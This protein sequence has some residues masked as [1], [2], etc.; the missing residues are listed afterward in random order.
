MLHLLNLFLILLSAITNA[1]AAES[2]SCKFA[3]GSNF[4][5]DIPQMSVPADLPDGTLLYKSPVT[6]LKL[7]CTYTPDTGIYTSGTGV[8][9]TT[10]SDFN[11]LQ[12][13]KKGIK[14]TIYLNDIPI[15][16]TVAPKQL[17]T[18]STGTSTNPS[19]FSTDVNVYF[20]IVVDRSRGPLPESGD[21]LVGS[22]ESIYFYIKRLYWPRA[23]IGFRT[24]KITAIPCSM[25]MTISPNTLDWG[26][27]QAAKLESG[28][29]F[30]ETF[31][32]LFNK[33]STCTLSG[34]GLFGINVWFDRMGGI[35]NADGSLDLNNGTGL[36]IRDSDGVVVP[37]DTYYSIPDVRVDS[38]IRKNFTAVVQKTS[39][40]DIKTGMFNTVLIVRMNYY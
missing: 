33:K 30:P 22:F 1:Y 4:I 39:G 29:E 12:N 2:G 28:S 9:Y 32:I 26:T 23:V 3:T 31:S 21:Q 37:F 25:D 7:N 6:Q 11:D 20:T 10:T 35:L 40:K 15:S 8:Y 17:G 5:P 14:L 38:L 13:Q 34:S 16:G 27:I 18:S 19:V 24:P 36:I